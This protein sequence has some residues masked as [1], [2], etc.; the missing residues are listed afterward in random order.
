MKNENQNFGTDFTFAV[1]IRGQ[2][3]DINKLIDFLKT[4]NLTIAHQEIGTVK[5]WI[6]RGDNE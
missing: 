4:C 6:K 3:E 5:M 2:L 1:V